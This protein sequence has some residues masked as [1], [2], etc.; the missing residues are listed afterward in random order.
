MTLD[1]QIL[2]ES[3]SP[4]NLTSWK[5]IANR[6]REKRLF[7]P[8][9]VKLSIVTSS[10]AVFQ[11]DS[12]TVETFPVKQLHISMLC[13]LCMWLV[14]SMLNF[15]IEKHFSLCH[16]LTELMMTILLFLNEMMPAR[17]LTAETWTCAM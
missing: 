8:I 5:H 4:H 11:Q 1:Y 13:F 14:I 12:I 3:P 2:L 6:L 15:R 17:Y 9:F 7:H 10:A 16:Q